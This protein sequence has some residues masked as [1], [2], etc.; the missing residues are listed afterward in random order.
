[1]YSSNLLCYRG[2][3]PISFSFND[4]SYL[5]TDRFDKYP[6]AHSSSSLCCCGCSCCC[7]RPACCGHSNYRVC[8][9]PSLLYGLR[10]PSL[11]QWS[12]SR[13]L[14]FGGGERYN[15]RLPVHS[16]D[17]EVSDLYEEGSCAFRER[18]GERRNGGRRRRIKCMVSEENNQ[19]RR[20][21]CFEDADAVL[22]LLSEE[23]DEEC[24]DSRGKQGSSSFKRYEVERKKIHGSEHTRGR[25][26]KGSVSK[27]SNSKCK[28]ESNEIESRDDVCSLDKGR[29]DFRGEENR[30]A[31][32]EVS[33]CSSY[34]S[35]SSSGGFESDV[36]EIKD[37]GFVG[38]TSSGHC[39]ESRRRD[40]SKTDN[41]MLE[42]DR[43]YGEEREENETLEKKQAMARSNVEWDWRKKSEKKLNEL[44]V[45]GAQYQKES[46]EGC[47][48][49]SRTHYND[50]RK[51]S[52]SRTSGAKK[53][54]TFS[55]NLDSRASI[56]H[57]Q[58]ENEDVNI[59]QLERQS[60]R[61]QE[62]CRACGSE[63]K[64][65]PQS[66]KQLSSR[67]EKLM[68]SSGS[69]L[70]NRNE[71]RKT[72]GHVAERDEFAGNAQEFSR[73]LEIQ[74]ID[75]EETSSLHGKSRRN[76]WEVNVNLG[77]SSAQRREEQSHRDDRITIEGRFGKS[78]QFTEPSE[79]NQTAERMSSIQSNRINLQQKTNAVSY[80]YPSEREQ[81]HHT[82][83]QA[84]QLA[85]SSGKSQDDV[86]KSKFRVNDMETA[87]S[88]QRTSEK[89]MASQD[90]NLTSVVTLSGEAQD[91]HKESRG[92][93]MQSESDSGS[94]PSGLTK[95]STSHQKVV[96]Q[97]SSNQN[98]NLVYQQN[99]QVI[100]QEVNTVNS[101]SLLIPP[102][103]QLVARG[104]SYADRTSGMPTK[105][106]FLESGSN[107]VSAHR[108][109][110]TSA[111]HAQL[112]SG[113]RG[114][115]NH[116]ELLYVR[117]HE[118]AL[119]SALRMEESSGKFVGEYIEKARHE[120]SSEA[121]VDTSD[122]KLGYSSKDN[123]Q[124]SSTQY[125]S[126]DVKPKNHDS[127]DPSGSSGSKGLSDEI[128]HEIDPSLHEVLKLEEPDSSTTSGPAAVRRSGRSLWNIMADIVR[129]HWRSRAESST[130][131]ARSGGKSTMNESVSSD[132]WFSGHEHD[133]NTGENVRQER[134]TPQK[135]TSSDQLQ[136]LHSLTRNRTHSPRGEKGTPS[137]AE[138]VSPVK[139]GSSTA[140]TVCSGSAQQEE[141]FGWHEEV[142]GT[143]SPPLALE[144]VESTL[145]QPPKVASPPR[146]EASPDTGKTIL[147]GGGLRE[148]LDQNAEKLIEVGGVEVTSSPL[149]QRKFQRV[150]QV[151]RD[152]FDD[153]EEAYR[154]ESDQRKID[155]MFMREALVEA[156][157][158]A[159][160][161][162]V[163]VGAVLV[164][165]GKIIAR[166]FNLVEELRDSTAHAEMIC[167]KEASNVLRSWRLPNYVL[168]NLIS[169][170][171][172]GD[173][174]ICDIGTLSHVCWS[175]APS[176]SQHS[177]M[178]SSQQASWSRWQLG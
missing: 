55:V 7:A 123:I 94:T 171:S 33:S 81:Y 130:S 23:V 35:F 63:V 146:G 95:Q 13:R 58:N 30:R 47:S 78:Q 28:L 21:S 135:V 148:G 99:M 122:A 170:I 36:E 145:P 46:L 169:I 151:T 149:K 60:K 102:P 104:S 126:Q 59:F 6:L 175:N 137:E 89:R 38:E 161:W 160:K 80:S 165:H 124:S 110:Q 69:I 48:K 101:Q 68:A 100:H 128:W 76:D 155:E 156:K 2:K 22:S 40:E 103:S 49:T 74:E 90:M 87:R 86:N 176:S 147:A 157:K 50:D 67:E 17:R 75:T 121:E 144:L 39:K 54:S 73:K 115:G 97:L 62:V 61:N 134:S 133:E 11:L 53:K 154:L 143:N 174:I 57:G 132:T 45:E 42:E 136:I 20:L 37:D 5:S 15:C 142:Q 65:S 117:T 127:R 158:A 98:I 152:R 9:S 178:G 120:I 88:S 77:S 93:V 177:C 168:V 85:H 84:L 12:A 111:L 139:S 56:S 109:T 4:N 105:E 44:S 141:D 91:R 125:G 162:E 108:E 27:D 159:E 10:Q 71:S 1:M 29:G 72:A 8:I 18:S 150:K 82:D 112:D 25:K 107:T 153:W 31:R 52:I 19:I 164:Q 114:D 64:V 66:E 116:G 70:K 96:E 41:E 140:K 113:G 119:G 106:N 24:F 32:K 16:I 79:S 26:K 163:P 129:L 51:S 172:P 118:D 138:V 167:I 173:N 92:K 166:G 34:H 131:A 3:G 43:I 83:S 14:Y